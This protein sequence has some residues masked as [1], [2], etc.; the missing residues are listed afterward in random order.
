M[1]R[2]G[3]PPPLVCATSARRRWR[4]NYVALLLQNYKCAPFETWGVSAEVRKVGNKGEW[5]VV[6]TI[7][8]L[9]AGREELRKAI[10]EFVREA[11]A[12]G[13][14]D[15]GKAEGWL[16]KLEKG[17]VLK[18]G[19]PR[20]H[21]GL[22][23][24]AL[25]VIYKT[26]NPEGILREVQRLR[27]MGLEEGRHF[28]VKMPEGGMEGYVRI[29]KEGLAYAAWLSVHGSDEQRRLAAEFVEY[30]LQRAWEAGKEVYEKAKEI[31][32]EGKAW[33]SLT[34]KGFKKKVEME[35]RVHVVKVIDGG[36][37]FDVGRGGRKLLRIKITAEIDGVR[38]D[39]T[40]T[41][42]RYDRN[43]AKGFAVARADAERYSAFVEALTGRKPRLYRM[44]DGR[45]KI[46]CYEGH[47][48][49]FMRYA[50][51]ADAISG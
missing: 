21:V 40:I 32:E 27:E 14:V 26:T 12:R 17:H 48:E 13:W 10:A 43:A 23:D 49:G 16:E 1:R 6:T 30:I 34:L 2:V 24:G 9:V 11:V 7:N 51:L 33:G 37:E 25:E 3:P 20:Y 5:Y 50:E 39:Y 47:L 44:K 46:E 18:E 31:I 4:D 41:Y 28:T 42:G 45:I 8:K 35:G 38:G 36:A 15:A 19:W 29:L 22:N